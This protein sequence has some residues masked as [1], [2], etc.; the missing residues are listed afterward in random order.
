[1][2]G[3]AEV[4]GDAEVLKITHL[5]QLGAIGSRTSFITFFRAKTNKIMVVCGCFLGDIE[6]FAA[7]VTKTHKGAKHE[8]TYM[9]AIELAKLQIELD[10]QSADD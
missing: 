3:D 10:E 1:M 9:L 6:E 2:S 8:K 5:F 4:Y 7:A